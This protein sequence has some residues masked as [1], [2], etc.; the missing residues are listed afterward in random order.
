MKKNLLTSICTISLFLIFVN[1]SKDDPTPIEE[2]ITLI[3]EVSPLG[4]G[5]INTSSKTYIIGQSITFTAIPSENYKFEKWTGAATGIKNPITI[6]I[7]SGKIVKANFIM[8]DSDS[9]GV[10]D[11]DDTCA[12]TPSGET[13]D[14]NGCS[15]SQKGI[16]N[17]DIELK[18]QEEVDNFGAH[19]YKD[20][21][22]NV[23]I[24]PYTYKSI[25]NLEALSSITII[26]G[27][28]TIIGSDLV[29]L[30][31]LNNLKSVGLSF[32]IWSVNNLISLSELESL[33]SVSTFIIE[34]NSELEDVSLSKLTSVG[35]FTIQNNDKIEHI[36]DFSSLTSVG[37]LVIHENSNLIDIDGFSS[38]TEIPYLLSIAGNNKLINI[39]G[40][41]GLKSINNLSIFE[42]YSLSN[43]DGLSNL[44]SVGDFIEFSGEC[45]FSNNYNLTNLDGLSS[46]TSIRGDL[47]LARNIILNNLS[48][49]SNLSAVGGIRIRNND[50]LTS[51][52]GLSSISS[53]EAYITVVDNFNLSDLCDLQPIIQ[54]GFSEAFEVT[55]NKYNPTQQDILDGRCSTSQIDTDGDGVMDADDTCPNTPIG[56]TV[57]ANGCCPSDLAKT[58]DVVLHYTNA[59]SGIDAWY[60]FQDTF[61]ETR[62]REYRT[63]E[64]S[65]WI[66]GTGFGVAGMTIL[67]DCG[68][69]TIPKQNLFDYYID[70]VEGSGYI[71]G[72]TGIIYLDYEICDDGECRVYSAVYTPVN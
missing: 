66:G 3:T 29:S 70:E 51:L 31:G 6:N 18:S 24:Y 55:G 16:Y 37:A 36:N 22:G 41:I 60:E 59:F 20:I 38:L 12:D 7:N 52:T 26:Q 48:G 43:V 49:L 46:L 32:Y 40:L 30:K 14:A 50:N 58:Y 62:V 72:D 61:T 8:A 10:M 68:S 27:G 15:D 25:S 65:Q 45:S 2:A 44:T 28:L 21:T 13:V 39:D 11:A 47:I 63:T 9:D 71:D 4:S 17:G 42:N 69:I 34:D 5:V 35:A 56:K 64:V 1:C 23:I 67:D 54:N 53:V 57:D 19:Q 33:S